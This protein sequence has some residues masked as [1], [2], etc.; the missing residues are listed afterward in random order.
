MS[1]RDSTLLFHYIYHFY[2]ILH[3]AKIRNFFNTNT[4]QNK[5]QMVNMRESADW[6]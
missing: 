2:V 6:V 1:N 5:I 3:V 4:F